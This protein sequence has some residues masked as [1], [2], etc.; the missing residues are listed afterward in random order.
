M[1]V[2]SMIKVLRCGLCVS[3]MS[4]SMTDVQCLLTTTASRPSERPRDAV[5]DVAAVARRLSA[6]VVV[7]EVHRSTLRADKARIMSASRRSAAW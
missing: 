5:A 3:W 2:P 4:P 6:A 1:S 7:D